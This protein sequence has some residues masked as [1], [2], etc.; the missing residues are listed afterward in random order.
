MAIFAEVTENECINKRHP[1]SKAYRYCAVTGKRY[2]IGLGC[3]QILFTDRKSHTGFRLVPKS[4]I[5][6]DPERCNDL[7]CVLCLR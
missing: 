2:E 1:L 3:K 7:R 5:F 6:N 4:M